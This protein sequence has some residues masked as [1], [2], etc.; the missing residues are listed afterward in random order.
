MPADKPSFVGD[1]TGACAGALLSFL[2]V[3]MAGPLIPLMA[4]DLGA[5]PAT[6]GLLVSVANVG[7]LVASVPSGILIGKI[8]SRGPMVLSTALIAGSCLFI[9]LYP[10][11]PSLFAGL[12]FFGIGRTVSAIGIQCYIG[13][14]RGTTDVSTNFGWYGAAV[15]VGQMAGPAVSGFSI[16]RLGHAGTW[17]LMG[18]I[19]AVTAVALLFLI[20]E[21][22]GA[23]SC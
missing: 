19:S 16:E 12:I 18:I 13:G 10:T 21:R 7:A 2:V 14:L 17:L 15:G 9:Y 3:A 23:R 5:R 6:L 4:L 1:L 11:L 22:R 8:G 20:W